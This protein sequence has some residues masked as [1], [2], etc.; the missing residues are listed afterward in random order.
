MR[1]LIIVIATLTLATLPVCGFSQSKDENAPGNSET[2]ERD[3]VTG[4]RIKRLPPILVG[5]VFATTPLIFPDSTVEGSKSDERPPAPQTEDRRPSITFILGENDAPDNA[6]YDLAAAVFAE[7]PAYQTD[8]LDTERRTLMAVSERLSQLEAPGKWG[9]VNIVVHGSPQTGIE[10]AIDESGHTA[11]ALMLS[12]WLSS[13]DLD[14]RGLSTLDASSVIRLYSCGVG[15]SPELMSELRRF[16]AGSDRQLPIVQATAKVI[17]F[18][19]NDVAPVYLRES[20][21]SIAPTRHLG[22]KRIAQAA[23]RIGISL[24]HRW[25]TELKSEPLVLQF[26][27]S[28]TELENPRSAKS[29][30]ANRA[31]VIHQLTRMEADLDDFRWQMIDSPTGPAVRGEAVISSIMISD[32]FGDPIAMVDPADG[33]WINAN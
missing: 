22:S 16:F 5:D 32:D 27:A 7:D 17:E 19:R 15:S 8:W 21:S 31:T 20:L 6:V 3:F 24:N 25:K 18:R 28:E 2:Q 11:N 30:A 9:T 26:G 12:H 13:R 14:N 33:D 29:I 23:S 4:S 10:A 1:N